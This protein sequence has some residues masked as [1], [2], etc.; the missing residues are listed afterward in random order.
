VS[1]AGLIDIES[2]HPQIATQFDT[3]SNSAV[4]LANILEVLGGTGIDTSGSGNTITITST[5]AGFAWNEI[6]GTSSGLLIDNGYI[7]N[8]AALVTLTL[9]TTGVIGDTIQIVGKGTGLYRIAQNA[10][11]IINFVSTSTSSGVGGSLTS[12]EQ[13]A[14]IELVCTTANTN[15]TVVDSAGNFTVV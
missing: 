14:S 5:A 8:N 2:S 15:W 6:T 12:I 11:Q 13:F 10:G 3:D 7:A 1:Q 9:P 4:P